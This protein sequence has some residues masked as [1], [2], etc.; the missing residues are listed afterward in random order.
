MGLSASMWSSVSGL[1]MHG[2]KMNVVGNNIA[3][4]STLGFKSQRMDFQDFIYQEGFSAAGTTQMGRGVNVACL[5]GDF[6]QGAFETTN[7]GTDLAIG[8]NGY[9]QVRSPYSEEMY[10]TRAGDFYF[11]KGGE[12]Q[13][14]SG[15]VLQGWKI[16]NSDALTLGTQLG[17]DVTSTNSAFKGTGTPTDIVLDTWNIAPKGTNRVG[18]MMNLTA[19]SGYDKCTDTDHPLTSLYNIWDGS[20]EPPISSESYA[21]QT[22][23]TVYDEAGVSHDLTVYLDQVTTESD[24]YTIKNLPNGYSVYEYIVTMKPGDDVRT[25]GGTYDATTES[26][27][28]AT[29]F[30]GTSAAGMLM[31]GT[32]TFNSSGQL[33][34]QSAYTYGAQATPADGVAHDGDPT[35]AESWQPTK[36][37]NNGYPVFSPNFTAQP[38][39]NSVSEHTDK[40]GT[41]YYPTQ[42]YAIELDLGLKSTSLLNPWSNK[43]GTLNDLTVAAKEIDYNGVSVLNT[44]QREDGATTNYASSSLT[45]TRTQNGYSSGT[46]STTNIDSYGV[47]SG[48]YSNGI[49]VDLYQISM[50]DFSNDQGLR[51]EGGNL[52]SQTQESGNP[53]IGVA[54]DSG[55]GA[56][57]AYSLEQSNVDLSREFVQ[58]ISTQRGFQANS[59]CI[60]TVDTMLE[61]VVNMKR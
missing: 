38:L 41:P 9:F 8:G 44:L 45:R 23:I 36:V 15:Y 20:K 16:D 53:A 11:N 27:T 33:V 31:V 19:E 49:S 30:A 6:S 37:S 29:P 21:T 7:S 24:D 60:T 47:I 51:R 46:L 13:N 43:D 12:L 4:V 57:S 10:Y 1:L 55:F 28:G 48:T 61:T 22:S 40:N 42:K 58:M 35:Q 34:N 14:P 2:E 18:L 59:K 52:Y 54:N 3:N 25:Y 26:M 56:I 50:Y 39:A 17:Y 5:M 32:L